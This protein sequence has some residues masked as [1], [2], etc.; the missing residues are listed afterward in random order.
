[1]VLG[2][3]EVV[4]GGTWWYMVVQ[5]GTW[6][7]RG[8]TWWYSTCTASSNISLAQ[9]APLNVKVSWYRVV[10]NDTEWYSVVGWPTQAAKTY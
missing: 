10:Q 9:S 5:G 3:T 6:W 8:G 1:M 4:Q 2:G 7:Y